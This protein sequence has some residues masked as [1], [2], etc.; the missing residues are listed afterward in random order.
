M[1]RPAAIKKA[2][3]WLQANN[4]LY[5]DVTLNDKWQEKWSEHDPDLWQAMTTTLDESN[6]D[7]T[8]NTVQADGKMG[9]SRE[10]SAPHDYYSSMLDVEQDDKTISHTNVKQPTIKSEICDLQGPDQDKLHNNSMS[11]VEP[12]DDYDQTMCQ[13]NG[14]SSTM[15]TEICDLKATNRDK[16]Q[17]ASTTAPVDND[18]ENQGTLDR[19]TATRG[20]PLDSCFYINNIESK[21]I[22]I[23]P[24]EGEILLPNFLDK[25]F[26]ESSNPD[27]YPYNTKR[28]AANR[29]TKLTAKNISIKE[30]LTLTVALLEMCNIYTLRSITYTI[31]QHYLQSSRHDNK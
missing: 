23:A 29:T 8:E 30:F 3:Q 10:Q 15:K 19:D 6:S 21:T 13:T 11:D 31:N 12:D 5:K 16:L 20:N 7:C 14:E 27:K 24:K 17:S 28:L 22:S 18:Q 4:I 26:E 25:V 2:L 1:V 9:K